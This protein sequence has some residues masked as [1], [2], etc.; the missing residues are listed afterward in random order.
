MEFIFAVALVGLILLQ[1]GKGGLSSGVSSDTY[2]TKRGAEKIIFIA[3][4]V[5]AII[6]LSISIANLLV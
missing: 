1:N 6:F 3:T 5:T 4:I 2:R